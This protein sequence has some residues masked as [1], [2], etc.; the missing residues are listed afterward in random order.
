[1]NIVTKIFTGFHSAGFQF[2][3]L[4]VVRSIG[5]LMT[6][7]YVWDALGFTGFTKGQEFSTP[8]ISDMTV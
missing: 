1:M 3:F 2:F 4:I 6:F 7:L 8:N 5:C